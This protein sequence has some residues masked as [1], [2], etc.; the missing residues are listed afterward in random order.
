MMKYL[1]IYEIKNYMHQPSNYAPLLFTM[2]IPAVLGVA[3]GTDFLSDYSILIV[4]IFICMISITTTFH[5][6]KKDIEEQLLQI[7]AGENRYLVS[8]TLFLA[9]LSFFYSVCYVLIPILAQMGIQSYLILSYIPIVEILFLWFALFSSAFCGS[10]IGYLLHPRWIMNKKN[11]TFLSVIIVLLII[12]LPS[13]DI[14]ILIW[15]IPPIMKLSTQLHF[16]IG[17][18]RIYAIALLFYGAVSFIFTSFL[19]KKIKWK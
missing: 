16:G 2:I 10:A 7:K 6:N 11:I 5:R 12:I 17:S 13:Q 8:K 15:F 1:L 9:G 4:V 14:S 19:L 3:S 18:Y